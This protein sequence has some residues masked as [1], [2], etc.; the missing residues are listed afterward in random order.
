MILD[1]YVEVK[2]TKRN[3]D[4]YLLYYKD[5]KLKDIIKI[6]NVIINRQKKNSLMKILKNLEL[7]KLASYISKN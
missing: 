3:I 1:K 5:I 6:I 2:I 7:K 4:H